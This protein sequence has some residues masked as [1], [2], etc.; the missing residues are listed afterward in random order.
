MSQEDREQAAPTGP[1]WRCRRSH[2]LLVL[3]EVLRGCTLHLQ[4]NLNKFLDEAQLKRKKDNFSV[5]EIISVRWKKKPESGT[6]TRNKRFDFHC[7]HFL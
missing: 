7:F 4:R 2:T 3:G 1:V 5:N 6:K